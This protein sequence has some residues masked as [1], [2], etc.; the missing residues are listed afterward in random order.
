MKSPLLAELGGRQLL[1][2]TGK[3]G[4]GKSAVA[5]AL[6][7]ASAAQGRRVRVIEADPRESLHQMLGADPS[8]GEV[9]VARPGL[10]FQ[11]VSARKVIDEIVRER[12]RFGPLVARTLDSPV[13][14]Q[15]VEGAPGLKELALLAHA[16]RVVAAEAAELV[17]LDAPASGHGRALLDAPRL[18]AGAVGPGPFGKLAAEIAS[19]IANPERVAVIAVALA[20]ELPVQETIELEAALGQVLGRGVLAVVVNGLYPPVPLESSRGG[21]DPALA[22]WRARRQSNERELERLRQVFPDKVVELPLLALE[23]GPALAAALAGL[24]AGAPR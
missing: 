23:R 4:T 16:Q 2:V 5:A 6:A 1:V 24:L 12:L 21:D 14:R 7:W 11:N 15:L 17:I 22:L 9:V 8:G 3:G 13:Y 18:V 10:E 20:E 19:W